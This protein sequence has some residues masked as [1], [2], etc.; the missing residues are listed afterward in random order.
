M[1]GTSL[2]VS[3]VV[4]M[5]ISRKRVGKVASMCVVT[6]GCGPRLLIGAGLE[7]LY[8]H[9]KKSTLST[10]QSEARVKYELALLGQ[11]NF[12]LSL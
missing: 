7:V 3:V 9:S 6:C 12:R 4:V 10:T 11:L 1:V 2:T 8:Y 5:K